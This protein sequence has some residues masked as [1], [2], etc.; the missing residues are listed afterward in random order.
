MTMSS[1]DA[2]DMLN[3]KTNKNIKFMM[4]ILNRWGRIIAIGK[5][6]ENMCI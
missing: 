3:Y 5:S 4:F 6:N 2:K 1:T